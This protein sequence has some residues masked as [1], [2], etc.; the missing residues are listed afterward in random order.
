MVAA[1]GSGTNRPGRSSSQAIALIFQ[2]AGVMMNWLE[3]MPFASNETPFI[4]PDFAYAL[5]RWAT[6]PKISV[7]SNSSASRKRVNSPA[8][9]IAWRGSMNCLRSDIS[10]V[11]AV[12]L[13]SRPDSMN[14][15]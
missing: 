9:T 15:S 7:V 14:R 8:R 6:L 3:I 4:V 1:L 5:K 13:I 2:P 10:G 12:F 11:E